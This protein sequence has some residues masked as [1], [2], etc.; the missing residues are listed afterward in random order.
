[1]HNLFQ[2]ANFLDLN[3]CI[4]DDAENNTLVIN[5][6][7]E[8]EDD[9]SMK[10]EFELFAAL[11][12]CDLNIIPNQKL[13]I[14][15]AYIKEPSYKCFKKYPEV[16]MMDSTHG[17]NEEISELFVTSAKDRHNI[18]FLAYCPLLNSLSMIF[19]WMFS[20]FF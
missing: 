2:S 20:T 10:E 7:L 18:F 19:H 15:S 14:L 6:Y 9:P 16:I 11:R 8:R 3:N 5:K 13:M 4:S 17:T 12:R 1:M